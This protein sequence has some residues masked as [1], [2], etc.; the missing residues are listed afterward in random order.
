M[1]K[2][3]EALS[4]KRA[5]SQYERINQLTGLNLRLEQH[6]SAI[7]LYNDKG[8]AG[9]WKSWSAAY[10]SIWSSIKIIELAY[11]NNVLLADNTTIA[12]EL[13]EARQKLAETVAELEATQ[14]DRDLCLNVAA[15]FA[16]RTDL[17]MK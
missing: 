6:G 14:A 10:K 12:R 8:P 4:K 2:T 13:A 16:K 5:E 11:M 15:F 3:S 7:L 17:N 9:Y 1:T